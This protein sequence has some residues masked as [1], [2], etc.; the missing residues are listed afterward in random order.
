[1][2]MLP[3]ARKTHGQGGRVIIPESLPSAFPTVNAHATHDANGKFVRGNEYAALAAQ[4][5]RGRVAMCV[6]LGLSASEMTT[7]FTKYARAARVFRQHYVKLLARTVGRGQCGPGP[8][9]ILQSAAIQMAFSRFFADRANVTQDAADV[10]LSSQLA[11]ES[12]HNIEAAV[13]LC[14]KEAQYRTKTGQE[15]PSEVLMRCLREAER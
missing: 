4:V 1:M 7:T 5:K 2:V 12:T 3:M 15:T 8:A 13:D 9:A 10:R 6:S 14:A 11:D